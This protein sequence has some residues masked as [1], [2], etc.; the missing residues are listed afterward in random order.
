MKTL[1]EIGVVLELGSEELHRHLQVS[2]T[3]RGRE[4]PSQ[5][6]ATDPVQQPV[7]AQEQ[8]SA[9]L[10]RRRVHA[11]RQCSTVA[12]RFAP[13][14]CSTVASRF[15]PLQCST[16]ASRFAPPQCS[17]AATRFAP[18]RSRHR[19]SVV[20]VDSVSGAS[21]G[22]SSVGSGVSGEG[23][24]SSRARLSWWRRGVRSGPLHE[25]VE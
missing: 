17:T 7:F 15:A 8:G 11:R 5:G 13:L 18:P 4:R 22:S 12:S 25:L 23:D 3:H 19:V 24:S 14:Q 16:A 2:S 10:R 20:T 9:R 6:P 21:S 1:F